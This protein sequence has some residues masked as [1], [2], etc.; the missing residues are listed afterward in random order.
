MITTDAQSLITAANGMQRI[1][2][3]RTALQVEIYLLQQIAGNTMT[4]Q[5][6]IA[7]ANQYQ[8]IDNSILARQVIVSLLAQIVNEV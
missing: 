5:Q 6:L 2:D 1:N 4:P 3:E 7:A 8:L